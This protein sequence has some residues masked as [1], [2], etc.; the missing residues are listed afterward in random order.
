MVLALCLGAAAGEHHID[1]NASTPAIL[2]IKARISSRESKLVAYKDSG[3]AGEAANGLI[4]ARSISGMNLAERKSFRDALAAEN[5]DR[6][7]LFR[8]LALVHRIEDASIAATAYAHFKGDNAAPRHWVQH[9]KTK[10]WVLK[11]DFRE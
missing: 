8:E 7:A 1:L 3:H 5:D 10:A 6:A 11:K 2:K 4:E 9:P